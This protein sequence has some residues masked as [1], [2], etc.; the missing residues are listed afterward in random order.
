MICFSLKRRHNHDHVI[1][2]IN[3]MKFDFIEE[4]G[5]LMKL[6]NRYFTLLA[7]RMKEIN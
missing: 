2:Q 3:W 5:Q 6:I 7:I 4:L 1:N